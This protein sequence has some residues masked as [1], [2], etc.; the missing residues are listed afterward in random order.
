MHDE[1]NSPN[2]EIEDTKIVNTNEDILQQCLINEGITCDKV[3][4][5]DTVIYCDD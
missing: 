3:A 5:S 1:L 4:S 2:M